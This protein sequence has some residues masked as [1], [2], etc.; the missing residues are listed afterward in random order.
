[1]TRFNK[2]TALLQLSTE[3]RICKIFQWV[4]DIDGHSEFENYAIRQV[5]LP[6]QCFDT[7]GWVI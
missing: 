3:N 5:S 2:L 1:V 6:L 7:V 4:N